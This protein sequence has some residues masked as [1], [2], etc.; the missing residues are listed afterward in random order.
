MLGSQYLRERL[1]ECKKTKEEEEKQETGSETGIVI[2]HISHPPG[3]YEPGYAIIASRR[4][5][6]RVNFFHSP[7]RPR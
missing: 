6:P 1:L 3:E 5:V 4:S 2:T 7:T